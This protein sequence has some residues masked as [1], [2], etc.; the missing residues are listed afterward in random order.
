[1]RKSKTTHVVTYR[2]VW[3]KNK[4]ILV[5]ATDNLSAVIWG[6]FFKIT[7]AIID[8]YSLGKLLSKDEKK[9]IRNQFLTSK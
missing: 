4:S 2:N 7:T 3:G 1:M 9:Q 8:S 6:T 5:D